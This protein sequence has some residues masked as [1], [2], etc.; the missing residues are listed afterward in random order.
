MNGLHF[1]P[2]VTEKILLIDGP[3][4]A[5]KMMVGPLASNL[6]GIDYAHMFPTVDHVPILAKLGTMSAD[7]AAAFLRLTV[8]H[9]VWDRMLGRHINIRPT[10]VWTV[11]RALNASE[12]MARVYRGDGSTSDDI[13][14]EFRAL[15][16]RF[17]FV[18]HEMLPHY[19]VW[20][21]A[22]PDVRILST[23]RHPVDICDSWR[24][25][26]WGERWGV[27]PLA[28][29]P[30]PATPHG[31]VPWFVL[32]D[33]ERYIASSAI[34]RIIM[35]VLAIDRE[36]REALAAMTA[37]ERDKV[38]IVTFE[39]VATDPHGEM[40]MVADWLGCEVPDGM[41]VVYARER[42]PRDLESGAREE[43]WRLLEKEGSPDLVEK[44]AQSGHAYETD[45]LR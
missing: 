16:T 32:D 26:G 23:L 4:R 27:D 7:D 2:A 21:K 35:G 20:F 43:K 9:S 38:K 11:N 31:P 29:I 25:R 45:W 24:R 6:S 12:V 18:V 1:K 30:V 14:A 37:E 36:Y 13:L 8:D 19:D 42:V 17:A 15:G 41:E 3:S 40:A 33:A 34:D 39:K 28:F 5:G 22:F 44:L 10:D